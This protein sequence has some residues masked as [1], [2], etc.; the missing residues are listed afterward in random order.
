MKRTLGDAR[1]EHGARELCHGEGCLRSGC[2]G[3]TDAERPFL[4]DKGTAMSRDSQERGLPGWHPSLQ[5]MCPRWQSRPSG[6][7]RAPPSHCVSLLCAPASQE[8]KSPEEFESARGDAAYYLPPQRGS[9]C[10]SPTSHLHS[11]RTDY[12]SP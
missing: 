2:P 11:T 10:A 1:A 4:G 5:G 8:R 3:D 7:T 9:G 6:Q 12:L